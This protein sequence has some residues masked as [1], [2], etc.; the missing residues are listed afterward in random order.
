[1]NGKQVV[2]YKVSDV[3]RV[4]ADRNDNGFKPT[5]AVIMAELHKMDATKVGSPTLMSMLFKVLVAGGLLTFDKG[6]TVT[7]YGRKTYL[8]KEAQHE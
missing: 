8:T 5:R 1:M 7:D 4:I 6:Y 2:S 3:I